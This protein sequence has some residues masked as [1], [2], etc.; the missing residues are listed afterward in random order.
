[1]PSASSL[2][3]T[4]RV[5]MV[6]ASAGIAAGAVFAAA[7]AADAATSVPA[8]VAH[9]HSAGSHHHA[10]HHHAARPALSFGDRGRAVRW[11]QRRL[12]VRPTAYFGHHTRHA[13]RRFQRHH[14]LPASGV[15]GRRTWRALHGR[16]HYAHTV[17]HARA[18]HA[19]VHHTSAASR[20]RAQKID[21][22]ISVARSQRGKPYVWGAAGPRAFDCSGYVQWVYRHALGRTLPHYTDSQYAATKHIHAR[23]HLR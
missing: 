19:H 17:H 15:V 6:L 16:G 2:S 22:V 18:H 12:G 10:R 21:R 13:V 20:T 23:A 4:H 11:V 3:A 5:R 14:G 7:P 1:M 9:H 8:A